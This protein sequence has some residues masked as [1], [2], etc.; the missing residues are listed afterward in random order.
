MGWNSWSIHNLRYAQ[1]AGYRYVFHVH[2]DLSPAAHDYEADDRFKEGLR[3]YI[4]DPHKT[5]QPRVP[6]KL[7]PKKLSELQSKW[8]F[9]FYWYPQL[10]R[11]YYYDRWEEIRR[12]YPEVFAAYQ[13][14]WEKY[15]GWNNKEDAFPMNLSQIEYVK[16]YK[17]SI[18]AQTGRKGETH[19]PGQRFQ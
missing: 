8:P 1:C 19:S 12:E 16:A 10:P 4:S 7:S 6:L 3:F 17:A 9:E 13:A 14:T 2:Q 5:I 15:F 18:L 11:F